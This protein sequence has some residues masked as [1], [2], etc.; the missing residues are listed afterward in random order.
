MSFVEAFY[1]FNLEINNPDS[2]V[3]QK[4]RVRLARHPQEELV[5]LAARVI[6]FMHSYSPGLELS[7]GLYEL[8]QP[9]MTH[10]DVTGELLDWVAVGRVQH[11]SLRRILKQ[12]PR[13]RFAV[14]FYNSEQ[15]EQFCHQLRGSTSN[16][17]ER[18]RFYHIDLDLIRAFSSH[19][20]SSNNVTATVLDYSMYIALDQTDLVGLITGINIW[21]KYQVSIG[22]ILSAD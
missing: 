7:A 22:N 11:G 17:V 13:T 15:I 21:E 18:I 2:S 4:V 19:L 9:D 16:W 8:D 10:V 5:N 1:T 6:A 20:K 14:Y 3:Y 12:N